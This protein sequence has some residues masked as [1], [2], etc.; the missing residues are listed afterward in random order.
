[1]VKEKEGS[2]ISDKKSLVV[3]ACPD[4]EYHE[5]GA[6][7]S[8]DF[9]E[10][11]GLKT[12]FVGSSTPKTEFPGLIKFLDPAYL[13]LGVTNSYNIVSAKRTIEEIKK[14]GISDMKIVVGGNAFLAR[15]GMYKEIGADFYLN[16]YDEIELFAKEV[17]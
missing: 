5:I 6:R 3:I 16:T 1:M 9:F 7:M 14:L 12:V 2:S 13:A 4:G 11:N 8:A 17:E 10:L 15:E